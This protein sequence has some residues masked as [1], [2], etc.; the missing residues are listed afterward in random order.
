MLKACE[1]ANDAKFKAR[2]MEDYLMLVK[3]ARQPVN[4]PHDG[5]PGKKKKTAI[6]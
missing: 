1:T 3:I 2:E 5:S 4:D 6:Y